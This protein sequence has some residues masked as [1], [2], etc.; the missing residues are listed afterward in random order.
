MDWNM[1]IRNRTLQGTA[2][3]SCIC[4]I[5]VSCSRFDPAAT[6]SL[7]DL[8]SLGVLIEP[9]GDCAFIRS[10]AANDFQVEM[11]PFPAAGCNASYFFGVDYQAYV[12]RE[13]LRLI[14][15]EAFLQQT[16]P[17]ACSATIAGIQGLI[18][19]P[20]TNPALISTTDYSQLVR[21]EVVDGPREGK[22]RSETALTSAG[23]SAAEATA[24]IQAARTPS[25][26]EYEATLFMPLSVVLAPFYGEP[27]CATAIHPTMNEQIPGWMADTQVDPVYTSA[28]PSSADPII[29]I[30]RCVFGSV[31]AGSLQLC[32]T[33]Q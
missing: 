17:S 5:A 16:A 6:E 26:A 20:A 11:R 14:Q 18:S 22:G 1:N 4:L 15:A 9:A 31:N 13:R 21:F 2:L 23:F 19:S 24:E 25:V 32:T 12:N 27:G 30:G 33:L 8:I 29:Y 10:P 28:G 3:I 7:E